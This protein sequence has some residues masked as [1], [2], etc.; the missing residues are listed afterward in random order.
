MNVV[1]YLNEFDG[2]LTFTKTRALF[3]IADEITTLYRVGR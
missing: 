2:V 3:A 1:F